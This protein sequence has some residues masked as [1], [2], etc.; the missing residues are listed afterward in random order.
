[1]FVSAFEVENFKRIVGT[2]I[3]LSPITIV[4][5]GNNSGKSCVLQAPH[6]AVNLLQAAVIEGDSTIPAQNLRYLPTGDIL[7]LPHGERL[8]AE[9]APVR[10]TFEIKT[11]VETT[12]C[13]SY[14]VG[15]TRGEGLNVRIE[16]GMDEIAETRLSDSSQP[17]TIYVP[18]LAG[19]P[20]RE[21]YR[22]DALI[23]SAIA[24]GDA[25]LYLRNVLLRIWNDPDKLARLNFYLERVLP[26]ASLVVRFDVPS[27]SYILAWIRQG[28]RE[29]PLDAMGTGILQFLQILA[30]VIEYSPAMVLLDEPDAH[31][32]PN[33]QRL[34]VSLL[35]DIVRDGST[36][37]VLAT[38]SRTLLDAFRGVPEA[39][40]VWIENGSIQAEAS[41]E[42]IEMLMS[43]GALDGGERFYSANC[44]AVFLTE[45]REPEY[46]H[47][48]LTANGINPDRTLIHS[49]LTS[50]RLQAAIELAKFI[51]KLKPAVRVVVHRDRDFMTDDDV[52]Q[53]EDLYLKDCADIDLFVT[54]GCDI[55]HYFTRPEHIEASFGV[56]RAEADQ[57]IKD[58]LEKNKVELVVSYGNKLDDL[59]WLYQKW[60]REPPK[61][62]NVMKGRLLERKH[63]HGKLLVGKLMEVA[64]GTVVNPKKKLLEPR[65]TLADSNLL[66]IA[67]KIPKQEDKG[68]DACLTP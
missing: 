28:D 51:K 42:H 47:A 57:L 24:R 34:I 13:R 4:V 49:Y 61:D 64:Q 46:I 38:H 32:H 66:A 23:A 10:V 54:E 63:A 27:D 41:Q 62:K 44:A 30:Y 21:E 15:L 16:S 36:Q 45:D 8:T 2:K 20:L 39:T 37:I 14:S 6:F 40:F 5:G 19:I 68:P 7:D 22:S 67:A 31:L 33:N 52:K 26:D 55:E 29:T 59:K 65:N 12:E 50:S 25:N 56:T 11:E 60:G 18:G 43:L 48:L 1:V 58:T 3:P 53:L 35:Q 9:T 17:F